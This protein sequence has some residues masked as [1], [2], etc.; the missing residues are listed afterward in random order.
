MFRNW[1]ENGGKKNCGN[2]G[3]ISIKRRLHIGVDCNYFFCTACHFAERE[4]NTKSILEKPIFCGI[5]KKEGEWFFFMDVR[6]G[7]EVIALL[8]SIDDKLELIR[9]QLEKL[10]QKW[11]I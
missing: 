2:C 6:Q 1:D 8:K 4:Y 3:N 10:N 9:Y 5:N 7:R 11:S